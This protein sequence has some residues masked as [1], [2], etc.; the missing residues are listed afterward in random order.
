MERPGLTAP[1]EMTQDNP[2]SSP[3]EPQ[4]KKTLKTLLARLTGRDSAPPRPGPFDCGSM[5]Q[6]EDSKREMIRG[7]MSLSTKV[8]REIMIPRVNV[9]AVNVDTTLPRLIKIIDDAGHS[10]IP[11]YH[12]RIDD[13]AGILY[14]K[15]LLRFIGARPRRFELRKILHKPCFVPETMPLDDLLLEFKRRTLHLACVLDEYGG[16]AGIVTL[17]DIL[18]E[19]VGEIKD[20]FDEDEPPEIKKLGRNSFEVDSHMTIS[21]F[22]EETGAAFPTEEFDTIGGMV[23]DLFG[24]IPKKNETIRHDGVTFRVK[25]IKGTR[26]NRLIVSLPKP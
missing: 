2:D 20:E 14:V 7:V 1:T 21:D 11:V 22:N 13:I 6:I 18:E 16:F 4:N 10:R 25:S 17:E 3:G 26:I 9:V 8:A 23:Y 12:D 5:A 15:N 19:I 24:K